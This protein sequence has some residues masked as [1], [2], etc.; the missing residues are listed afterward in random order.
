MLAIDGVAPLAKMAQQRTRRFMA[1]HLEAQRKSLEAT[2]R[3]SVQH[4]S[5]AGGSRLVRQGALWHAVGAGGLQ[6]VRQLHH[7]VPHGFVW[8]RLN[9]GEALE[10]VQ[11]CQW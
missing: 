4:I 2:V 8:D 6:G 9:V 11:L 10:V 7:C 5:L 3:G 1:A